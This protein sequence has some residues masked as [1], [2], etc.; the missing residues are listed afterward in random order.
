MEKFKK[1]VALVLSLSVILGTIPLFAVAED[2]ESAKISLCESLS[3]PSGNTAWANIPQTDP[4]GNSAI[5]EGVTGYGYKAENTAKVGESPVWTYT[6]ANG[7]NYAS[8]GWSILTD[9]VLQDDTA[10]ES[11]YNN[12]VVDGVVYLDGSRLF[13]DFVLD[14][15]GYYD[16]SGF[17]VVGG[18][19]GNLNPGSYEIYA[20]KTYNAAK[21][22]D[23]FGAEELLINYTND[24][25][26]D[27]ATTARTQFFTANEKIVARFVC[28][29]IL[30]PVAEKN[31]TDM[32]ENWK[33]A[34]YYLAVRLSE[35]RVYG[36]A[37]S[38]EDVDTVVYLASENDDKTVLTDGT[39]S[40]G[41]TLTQ[42]LAHRDST[43]DP[44]TYT[45]TTKNVD[46]LYKKSDFYSENL[47]TNDDRVTFC[48][49]TK[50]VAYIDGN[51]AFADYVYD[52][53]AY[54]DISKISIV[55]GTTDG[56]LATGKYQIFASPY[57]VPD[58]AENCAASGQ[59]LVEYENKDQKIQQTFC[60]SGKKVIA[61]YVIL[62]VINPIPWKYANGT[63]IPENWLSN[64]HFIDVRL[65]QFRVYGDFVRADAVTYDN[66]TSGF[67]DFADTA[68]ATTDAQVEYFDKDGNKQ[69]TGTNTHSLRDNSTA[70]E[71]VSDAF[72]SGGYACISYDLQAVKSIKNI[73]ILQNKDK[74][75][76]KYQIYAANNRDELYN[77]GNKV[78]EIDSDA[79]ASSRQL[80]T[81]A[82]DGDNALSARYVGMK[83]L[84]PNLSDTSD[85]TANLFEFNVYT[86][87]DGYTYE[88][89][90]LEGA[91]TVAG[92]KKYEEFTS[93]SKNLI[94]DIP[95]AG[96]YKTATESG[97]FNVS[98]NL[99]T[100]GDTFSDIEINNN[101]VY[102]IG[103]RDENNKVLSLKDSADNYHQMTWELPCESSVNSLAFFGH[104]N[105][106]WSPY[107][108][109]VSFADTKAELFTD[110]AKTV[111]FYSL[112]TYGKVTL[113]KA[114]NC[115]WVA[116]RVLCGVKP[117]FIGKTASSTTIYYTRM[118]H[119]DV[120]GT[121]GTVVDGS[122]VNVT[123]DIANSAQ[124][125]TLIGPSDN[126]G[127]KTLGAK[128][129][130]TAKANATSDGVNYYPFAG[131]YEGANLLSTDT[132]YYYPLEDLENHTVTAKYEEQRSNK[133]TFIANGKIIY[134]AYTK[135]GTKLNREDIYAASDAVCERFGLYKKL[136]ENLLQIW[137]DDVYSDITA[138]KTVNALYKSTADM[139]DI[140][141]TYTD[142]S[143]ETFKKKFDERLDLSDASA[144]LWK[145]NGNVS[146]Y[147][148]DAVMYVFGNMELWLKIRRWRKKHRRLP[149]YER[150]IRT[151]ALRYLPK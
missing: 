94:A 121:F 118:Y 9:G 141:V 124:K 79:V 53:G 106:Q 125:G 80:A 51:Y 99:T 136:D 4:N 128:I 87:Y 47:G 17:N 56:G 65:S 19:T 74:Y 140:T 111:D 137:D 132:V 50:K 75:V 3:S 64:A 110:S 35:F 39:I 45:A 41:V 62:R 108:L 123:S 71:F 120:F 76:G 1:A 42:Y 36:K 67:F 73:L 7:A 86:Y 6:K 59:K 145:V 129:Q 37:L 61:R 144:T 116:V 72:S 93:Y 60:V 10:T 12:C 130:L 18:S 95:A 138:D 70:I 146:A 107:H 24:V 25:N 105:V 13:Y 33:N 34:T 29:R 85:N 81:F 48:D 26:G 101:K 5:T 98:K 92:A 46:H 78:F 119:F 90:K 20:A 131:W 96:S 28:L 11:W 68:P 22:K 14:L 115:K 134:T 133:V 57:F 58:K 104:R 49:T 117:S 54:Y 30:N 91:D 142:G 15:G 77:S 113:D 112:D 83:I 16:L 103:E 122:N 97:E 44:F 143:T 89:A 32:P 2:S 151:T 23:N 109:A 149:L 100:S 135:N 52:L 139:Y 148:T 8:L 82:A 27:G 84:K 114:V 127:N 38:D 63:E 126:N 21:G 150:T 69:S 31:K 40:D 147:G 55:H 66:P 43:E 102:Y 88:G